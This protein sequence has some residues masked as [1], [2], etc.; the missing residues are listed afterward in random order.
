M[1][2]KKEKKICSIGLYL[3]QGNQLVSVRKVPVGCRA[4]AVTY[5]LACSPSSGL[6]AEI[7]TIKCLS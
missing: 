3:E 7:S 2:L 1:L 4:F 6:R 5:R